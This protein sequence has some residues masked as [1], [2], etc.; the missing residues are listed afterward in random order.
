MYQVQISNFEVS[1]PNHIE[2]VPL[3]K[4]GRQDMAVEFANKIH[5]SCNLPHYISVINLAEKRPT[6]REVYSIYLSE[7][8]IIEEI[9]DILFNNGIYEDDN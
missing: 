2:V 6:K 5:N 4:F 1:N 9:K 8:M 3:S 7:Y